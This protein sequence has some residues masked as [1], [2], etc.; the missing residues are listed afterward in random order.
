MGQRGSAPSA[1]SESRGSTEPS[2]EGAGQPAPAGSSGTEP[3]DERPDD[4]RLSAVDVV[5]LRPTGIELR[6]DGTTVDTID[7]LDPPQDAV[8]ALTEMFERAPERQTY[9]GSSHHP[10][11]VSYSWGAVVLDEQLRDERWTHVAYSIH[12]PRFA[13]ALLAPSENGIT[14][15]SADAHRVGE[16]W[17]FVLQDRDSSI[18]TCMG[19]AI[20][21]EEDGALED[22]D[23]LDG[24]GRSTVV[25]SATDRG[26][27]VRRLS[28]PETEASG[29]A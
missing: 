20:D 21:S 8:A 3:P 11:G 19:T 27:S 28:A 9:P 15:A 16:P 14:L 2:D 6:A 17:D 26:S 12:R 1:A 29:C 5:V 4:L 13:I 25:A 7:F 24:L 18:R 23:E 10:P 22:G